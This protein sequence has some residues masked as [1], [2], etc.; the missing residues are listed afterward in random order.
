MD[1][2]KQ[3]ARMRSNAQAV[4]ASLIKSQSVKE[5]RICGIDEA[6]RGPLAGPVVVAAVHIS[7]K[8]DANLDF[9]ADVDDSKRMSE[10]D[11]ER[12]FE[13]LTS[14][15]E[16]RYAVSSKSAAEID[17]VNILQAT[18]MAMHEVASEM[19][20]NS[21]VNFVLID[22]NRLPWGHEK[23]VRKDGSIRPADP[24]MPGCIKGA[25]SVIG[26]DSTVLCIAAAS[27][28]AKVTRDKIMVK[29]DKEFP[30]YGFRKHKGYGTREHMQ[31]I[32]K[33]GGKVGIHRFTFAPLKDM[34]T[35][36]VK[37]EKGRK[38]SAVTPRS[39]R[40]RRRL[41]FEPK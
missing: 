6:G 24:A 34:T 33:H 26:G 8:I 39:R 28:I 27:I 9:L 37:K 40:I 31:Q 13:L 10:K 41:D 36:P 23:A 12:L 18:M 16:I 4:E 32:R 30:Q 25:E 20:E 35:T 7:S 38:R 1:R 19:A 2:E 15:P 3:I 21:G 17:R 11:R 14:H 5:V 29:L 22:G